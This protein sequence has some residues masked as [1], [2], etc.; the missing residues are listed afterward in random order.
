VSMISQGWPKWKRLLDN[1]Q[2][3][4]INHAS[5]ICSRQ[6]TGNKRYLHTVLFLA[7]VHSETQ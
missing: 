4:E 5:A 1:E 7:T 6:P 2:P 3:E